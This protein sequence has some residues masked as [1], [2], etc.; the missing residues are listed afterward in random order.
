MGMIWRVD[1]C[2]GDRG[3][4]EGLCGF[5]DGGEERR[6]VLGFGE[7]VR[8]FGWV[9]VNRMNDW[10]VGG[11]VGTR[12]M[13][14][15]KRV[16]VVIGSVHGSWSKNREGRRGMQT[17]LVKTRTVKVKREDGEVYVSVAFFG[18]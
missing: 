8:V 15:S 14:E 4:D 12:G 11:G 3:G 9:S 17:G 6:G 2:V 16:C 7:G 1:M 18:R 5:K 10:E 13:G